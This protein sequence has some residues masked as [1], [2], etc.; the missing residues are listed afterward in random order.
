MK[1]FGTIEKSEQQDD[2]TII[3][4]GFASS[5]DTDS[6]GEVITSDAMKAALPDYMKFANIREMHQAKAAGVALKTEVQ[7]DGRT[8]L[9]ALIVDDAAVKK[10][11]KGV[12]K[13]FSI[14]GKVTSRDDL[15][16]SIITGIRLSEISLVDRPANPS[17]VFAMWKGE[18]VAPEEEVVVEP[19]A[20][21]QEP[22]VAPET[23]EKG[24]THVAILACILKDIKSL[25][26]DQENE[27][28]REGDNSPVPTAIA[29]W[30][31]TGAT[32]L[33]AMTAEETA[34][35]A[36]TENEPSD[37][38]LLAD[39]ATDLQK[40]GARNSKT[41]QERIQKIHDMAA[42]IGALCGSE[43]SQGTDDL[44]K[45]Q[46]EKVALIAKLEKYETLEKRVK[47]LE[48]MPA[49]AKAA[50]KVVEKADD[51]SDA[52]KNEPEPAADDILG[53]IKKVHRQGA[54]IKLAQLLT[55]HPTY[56]P[57]QLF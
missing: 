29:D 49:P 10:V 1:L 6:D 54:T 14:G 52:A 13:G 25:L 51:Y 35:L 11:M 56:S 2:G 27:A 37:T 24:M 28:E 40:A 45:L 5:T 4:S 21:E 47:E 31:K 30:L 50:L 18:G 7:D 48:A 22:V 17:A 34:E 19:V 46:S 42:E 43:K 32:L 53:Q 33:N 20:I 16:K 38:V 26:S 8:Y 15:N 55:I 12:Y 9:E 39:N 41:D 23:T 36:A 3:V 44:A 57:I